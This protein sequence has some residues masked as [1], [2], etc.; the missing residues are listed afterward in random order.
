[1][2]TETKTHL[3]VKLSAFCALVVSMYSSCKKTNRQIAIGYRTFYHIQAGDTLSWMVI[4]NA[5]SPNGDGVNDYFQPVFHSGPAAYEIRIND[6]NGNEIFQSN[7]LNFSD[8][9]NGMNLDK[10][11]PTQTYYY[12][13]KATDTSNFTYDITGEVYLLR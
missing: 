13:L 11:C 7:S 1:M 10:K 9:W 8:G 3:L 2:K 4:P 5:F 6:L 12:Y